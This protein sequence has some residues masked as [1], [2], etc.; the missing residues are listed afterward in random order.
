MSQRRPLQSREEYLANRNELKK[1]KVQKK[2]VDLNS[3]RV[4]LQRRIVDVKD[5]LRGFQIKDK[6]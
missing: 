3:S 6:K 5:K 2:M 4:Q 1:A